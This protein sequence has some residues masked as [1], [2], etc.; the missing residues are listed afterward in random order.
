MNTKCYQGS[1]LITKY[2]NNVF[3]KAYNMLEKHSLFYEINSD[4]ATKQAYDVS[5]N[6]LHTR[7]SGMYAL[8]PGVDFNSSLK[9]IV[10]FQAI[11]YYI[12]FLCSKNDE[13]DE[14]LFSQLYLS[15]SDAVDPK[16]KIAVSNVD[17]I[18]KKDIN[19]IMKLIEQCRSHIVRLP[20]YSLVIGQLK[21]FIQMY[22]DYRTYSHLPKGVREKRLK[23][24]SNRY[25]DEKVGISTWEMCAAAGSPLLI[26]VLFACA[27]DPHL[28][29]EEVDNICSSYFPWICGLHVLISHYIDA[30]ED[31][32]LGSLNMTSFYRNLKVCED[33]ISLFITEA[34]QSCDKLKYPEF[35]RTIVKGIVAVHLSDPKAFWGMN[36]LASI[37][38]LKKSGSK[39]NLYHNLCKF[40]RFSGKL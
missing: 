23:E 3:P 30:Y 39:I 31:M 20:S 14:T 26:S 4:P 25:H 37:N 5:I 27:Y 7:E 6:K 15:L 2:I 29:G 8:Y 38:L 17:C 34:L 12:H 28:T 22:S 18:R 1:K 10:S 19:N 40:L 33:R 21:K 36:R 35:H 32:L 24:W 9:F 13:K 11:D 16:R